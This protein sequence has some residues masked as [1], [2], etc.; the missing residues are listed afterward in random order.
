VTS[1]KLPDVPTPDRFLVP[2]V[3]GSTAV[4]VGGIAAQV[5]DYAF[6]DLRIRVLDSSDDG[7]AFGIFGDLASV[8]AAAAAW[9]L[10]IRTRSRSPAVLAPPF[11]L[12]F[13]A[14]DKTLRLH[15]HVPH[16][17]VVYA[18]AL[19]GTFVC[20]A[21]LGHRM[22]HP[23]S[24]IL[25][26]GLALLIV[27]FALHVFGEQLLSWLALQKSEGI[28]QIKVALKHGFEV[29]GWSLVAICLTFSA[30]SGR[31]SARGASPFWRP[32]RAGTPGG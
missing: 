28:R 14:M 21:A 4:V 15:D 30:L 22:P 1:P 27:S 3:I 17:L 18:P 13:L 24:Q 9:L 5:I 16:Y 10:L 6:F 7:G 26:A 2:A 8:A 19:V 25:T 11:L 20:L 32:R 29:E 23:L 12:T 31:L